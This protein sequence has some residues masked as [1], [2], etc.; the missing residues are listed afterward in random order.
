MPEDEAFYD[1]QGYVLYDKLAAQPW[2]AL[3]TIEVK[4]PTAHVTEAQVRLVA[5]RRVL[6]LTAD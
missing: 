3:H 4:T 6:G 5:E 2:F 1:A